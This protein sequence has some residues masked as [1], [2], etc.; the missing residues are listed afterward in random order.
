MEPDSSFRSSTAHPER[1]KG[2]AKEAEEKKERKLE[3]E[4]KAKL[5]KELKGHLL[6]GCM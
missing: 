3:S 2:K 6:L 5:K 1:E 4:R